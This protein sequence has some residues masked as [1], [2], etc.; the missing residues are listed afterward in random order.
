MATGV[1]GVHHGRRLVCGGWAMT[2]YEFHWRNGVSEQIYGDS[3]HD[4]LK[5]AG[6]SGLSGL[7]HYETKRGLFQ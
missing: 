4:A 2:L 7:D 1:H 5:R 3:A 6:Y